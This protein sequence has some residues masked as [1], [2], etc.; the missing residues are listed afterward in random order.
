[1]QAQI[2]IEKLIR[3]KLYHLPI[4]SLFIDNFALEAILS[5]I[6]IIKSTYLPIRYQQMLI[7]SFFMAA[8]I[9][10]FVWLVSPMSWAFA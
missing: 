8:N 6:E 3:K 2:W 4:F 10:A 7:L 9:L 5:S 1:M